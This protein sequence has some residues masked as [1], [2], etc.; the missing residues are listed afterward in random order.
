MNPLTLWL[1]LYDVVSSPYGI[2]VEV[3]DVVGHTVVVVDVVVT[4]ALSS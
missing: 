3:V 2:R 4:Q 1:R